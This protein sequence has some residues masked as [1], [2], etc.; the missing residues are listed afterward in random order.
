MPHPPSLPPPP[1]GFF[2]LW[3]EIKILHD[4]YKLIQLVFRGEA[5]RDVLGGPQR[6]RL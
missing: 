5:A 6:V 1:P 2:S 3:S 4:A